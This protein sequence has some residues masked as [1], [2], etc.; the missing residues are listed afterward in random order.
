MI[1]YLQ[2]VLGYTLTG[3][4]R[5]HALFFI[6]GSGKNGKSVFLNTAAKILGSLATTAAMDTFAASRGD[7]HPTELARLDGARLVSASE[8]EEGRAWAE[9]RIKQLTGGDP[10]AARYMKQDFFTFLPRFKLLIVGNHQPSLHNVDPATRR[11]FHIIPFTHTPPAPDLE[12]ER[13][14]EGEHG[15]ILAWMIE[16]CMDWQRNGLTRP[17]AVAAATEEYFESQDMMGQWIAECCY[18]GESRWETPA[19]LFSSWSGFARANGEEAG[20]TKSFGAGLDRRGYP[21]SKS[22]GIRKRTGISLR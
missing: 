10:I 2:R 19:A 9:A 20:N 16:G 13:K 7:R 17:A 11:R 14:L 12:L 8:T 22:N 4:T 15:R 1:L 5:E 6:Y 3:D 21:A 18:V